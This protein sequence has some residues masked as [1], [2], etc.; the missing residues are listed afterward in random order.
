[1]YL[2]NKKLTVDSNE[3]RV[4]Q[5]AENNWISKVPTFQQTSL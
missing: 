5:T 1:M 2:E 3:M 4:K